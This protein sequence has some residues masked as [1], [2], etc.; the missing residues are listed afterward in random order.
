LLTGTNTLVLFCCCLLHPMP[1]EK[2]PSYVATTLSGFV[3]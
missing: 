3:K 2:K 1:F